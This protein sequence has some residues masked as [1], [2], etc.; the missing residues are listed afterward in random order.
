MKALNI[1]IANPLITMVGIRHLLS[2]IPDLSGTVV[3][4]SANLK[5]VKKKKKRISDPLN[6]NSM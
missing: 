6:I 2:N 1:V 5:K 4:E 3:Q